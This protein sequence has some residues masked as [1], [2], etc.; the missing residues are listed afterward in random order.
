M[1]PTFKGFCR[2]N[3]YMV[4]YSATISHYSLD[5]ISDVVAELESPNNENQNDK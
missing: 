4:C 2:S 3:I 5:L 1:I